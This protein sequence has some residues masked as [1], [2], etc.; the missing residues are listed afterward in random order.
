[1]TR[2][3]D[4]GAIP[5]LMLMFFVPPLSLFSVPGVACLFGND[6]SNG[7]ATYAW[8]TSSTIVAFLVGILMAET[9]VRRIGYVGGS[10]R[11]EMAL[12]V[13]FILQLTFSWKLFASVLNLDLKGDLAE[14]EHGN[15]IHTEQ[16]YL[17]DSTGP[18]LA[19]SVVS[20]LLL[21]QIWLGARFARKILS[22][23][24]G[25]AENKWFILGWGSLL[26]PNS[27]SCANDRPIAPRRLEKQVAFLT[28]RFAT[29]APTWQ[30]VIWA[31]QLALFIVG[32][33]ADQTL[34]GIEDSAPRSLGGLRLLYAALAIG[35]T[36]VAWRHHHRR[37]PYYYRFQ[38]S[39]EAWL[40]FST[41]SFLVL[42]CIYSALPG[43]RGASDAVKTTRVVVE[44]ILLGVLLASLIGLSA[45]ALCQRG[46][47]APETH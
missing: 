4:R 40:Y 20:F 25:I 45:R 24:R 10:D 6:S 13:V 1:M 11:M 8:I 38:N 37:Q 15:Y 12:S 30:L 42:A 32:I 44:I 18:L 5:N 16:G 23:K 3:P 36:L 46:R 28:R 47:K 9:F 7:S 14:N 31:R 35:V 33:V 41:V 21:L 26:C 2:Y 17:H 22:Y 19:V 27:Q 39:I 29:H 34:P 43:H